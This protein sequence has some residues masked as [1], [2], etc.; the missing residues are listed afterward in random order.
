MVT[1]R[2]EWPRE[3]INVSQICV[4][5]SFWFLLLKRSIY[6]A[7]WIVVL[8]LFPLPF[9]LNLS[10]INVTPFFEILQSPQ[11]KTIIYTTYAYFYSQVTA[12]F[13]FSRMTC[14]KINRSTWR[15]VLLISSVKSVNCLSHTTFRNN[16]NIFNFT[17]KPCLRKLHIFCLQSRLIL[18]D[19]FSLL[20]KTVI[21]L[22]I[23]TIHQQ[24]YCFRV[25]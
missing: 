15:I 25:F 2:G 3:S 1:R 11:K 12:Y 7:L 8:R 16:G 21:Y 14:K 5:V 10:I 22:K 13:C 9:S 18:F 17:V 4:A 23:N 6:L 19:I 24:F 20:E